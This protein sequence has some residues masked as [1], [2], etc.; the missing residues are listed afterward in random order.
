[1]VPA[2]QMFRFNLMVCGLAGLGIA[3]TAYYRRGS[4]KDAITAAAVWFI[5]GPL[6]AFWQYKE[7]TDKSKQDGSA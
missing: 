3:V 5:L 6:I 1:M 4:W 2:K 7:R